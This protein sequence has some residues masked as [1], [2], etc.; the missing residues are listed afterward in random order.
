VSALADHSVVVTAFITWS[1]T[2]NAG[3][4]AGD[5]Q[6]SRRRADEAWRDE[7]YDLVSVLR[8]QGIDAELDL[9]HLHDPEVDWTR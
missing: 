8:R 2:S 1:H 7:V 4:T 3:A 9:A 5:D 6:D